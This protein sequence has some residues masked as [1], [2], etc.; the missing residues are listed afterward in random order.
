M[1]HAG[2]HPTAN[3]CHAPSGHHNADKCICKPCPHMQACV[4][5][6]EHGRS[7]HIIRALNRARNVRYRHACFFRFVRQLLY[8]RNASQVT[9]LAVFR[10]RT[11]GSRFTIDIVKPMTQPQ[12]PCIV[13]LRLVAAALRFYYVM[14]CSQ[15]PCILPKQA[16]TR[17]D[18]WLQLMAPA[19][20]STLPGDRGHS[21][22]SPS[23]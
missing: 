7:S 4:P 18:E 10:A 8:G 23:T 22:C 9:V 11:V 19:P 5:Q 3:Q 21:P 20:A 6:R 17:H 1:L 16:H 14:L 13:R 15:G 12:G 2:A